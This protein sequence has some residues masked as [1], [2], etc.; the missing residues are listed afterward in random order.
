[1]MVYRESFSK[2]STT[3]G[4]EVSRFIYGLHQAHMHELFQHGSELHI[5]VSVMRDSA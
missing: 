1:M 2:K 3:S 4:A 5:F